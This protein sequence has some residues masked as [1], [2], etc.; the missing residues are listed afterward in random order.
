MDYKH[1]YLLEV[2]IKN[3][4]LIIS[5]GCCGDVAVECC[6]P[7]LHTGL[8]MRTRSSGSNGEGEV[9]YLMSRSKIQCVLVF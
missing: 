1:Y 9:D 3:I 5:H 4:S 2:E 6:S 7:R 8:Y